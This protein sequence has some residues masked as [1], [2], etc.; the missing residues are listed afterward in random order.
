MAISACQVRR[1]VSQCS[2]IKKRTAVMMWGPKRKAVY[3]YVK[4]IPVKGFK[5]RLASALYEPYR[6]EYVI[7]TVP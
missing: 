1:T 5:A 4:R 2:V 7:L 6:P 3:V